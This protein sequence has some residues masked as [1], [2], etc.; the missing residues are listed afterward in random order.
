MRLLQ[1]IHHTFGPHITGRFLVQTVAIALAPWAYRKGKSGER[2]SRA[3]SEHFQGDCFLFASGREGLLAFL[4]SID[5]RPGEE[6]IVQGYTCVVVPNA[7][8]AAGGVPVYADIDQDTLNLDLASVRAVMSPRTRVIICQHTF[9]IPGEVLSLRS[10]CDEHGILLVEDLAHFI[11]D[12]SDGEQQVG[13]YGDAV[14]LSF[15]RDKAISGIAGG[16]MICRRSSATHPLSVIHE[17]CVECSMLECMRLL[18]Y[19]F[20]YALCRPLMG[21]GI[22]RIILA[23]ARAIGL[24]PVI[25]TEEEKRGRMSPVLRRMPNACSFLAIR[26]WQRLASINAH[27]RSLTSFYFHYARKSGWPVL[28]RVLPSLALQKFPLFLSGAESIRVLLKSKNIHLDDGW[29]GCTVCP[30]TVQDD[31]VDYRAGT[32]PRAEVTGTQILSLPTHP[33]MSL[34]QARSL[35]EELSPFFNR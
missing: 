12:Q 9:G 16:A 33:T 3:L 17:S 27:R 20:A 28:S 35:V 31:C 1:P 32:S 21:I 13:R 18:S 8:H 22:G 19:S 5:L 29:T 11:P 14:L 30:C 10:L 2:L 7:I 23:I 26:Q 25:L 15:G 34:Q 24:M 4:R 6:V